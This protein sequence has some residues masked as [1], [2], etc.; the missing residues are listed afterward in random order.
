M[1]GYKPGK[2]ISLALDPASSEFYSD[3]VYELKSEGKKLSSEEMTGYYE[4]MVAVY[5]IISIE[6]GAL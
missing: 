2:D 6:D 5:P 1:A 3:G 4:D